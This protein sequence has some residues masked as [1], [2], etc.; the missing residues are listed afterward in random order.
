M[1]NL[2]KCTHDKFC[3][4]CMADHLRSN[5]EDGRVVKIK[6]MAFKCDEEFS[7]G[8]V[9]AFGSQEIYRKYLKFK[10]NIDVETNPALKWCSKQGCMGYVAQTTSCL[11]CR[12][13][14]AFCNM[15]DEATCFK[16][17]MEFHGGDCGAMLN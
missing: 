9:Q 4:N 11:C 3:R 8:D 14:K 1:F 5:V 2:P 13:R 17:G 7:A 15:C 12:R 10:V 16:C 6:C